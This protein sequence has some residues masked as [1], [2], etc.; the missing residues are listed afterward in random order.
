MRPSDLPGFIIVNKLTTDG[1]LSTAD[2]QAARAQA[3]ATVSLSA[4]FP[5]F[6]HNQQPATHTQAAHSFG[7]HRMALNIVSRWSFEAGAFVVG[8]PLMISILL[9]VVWPAVAVKVFQADIQTSVQTSFTIASYIITAGAL[10]IA[11][12]AFL[13]TQNNK[14]QVS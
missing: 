11:L 7:D 3:P 14:I 10:I 8:M 1:A 4:A 13:D 5:G 2:A 6:N 12:V 9:A